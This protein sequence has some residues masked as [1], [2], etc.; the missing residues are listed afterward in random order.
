MTHTKR[1]TSLLLLA[2]LLVGCSQNAIP[3]TQPS[4]SS[5]PAT[6]KPSDSNKSD[7]KSDNTGSNKSDDSPVIDPDD[8]DKEAIIA[9]LSEGFSAENLITS[10]T[11]GMGYDDNYYAFEATDSAYSFRRYQSAD[12]GFATKDYISTQGIYEPFVNGGVKYLTVVE[13]GLD[14][15]LHNYY[16]V[17]ANQNYLRWDTA[18]YINPFARLY[19]DD[20][21]QD[22]NNPY[23]FS[24]I[25][26]D[27]SKTNLYNAFVTA[28]TGISGY[29]LK[30]FTLITDGAT[31]TGYT[32]QVEDV[33]GTYGTTKTSIKGTIDDYK[34]ED[35][36]KTLSPIE[37]SEKQDLE[38]RFTLLRKG[39]YKADITLPNRSYKAEVYGGTAVTY[40]LYKDD[41]K[42]GSYGYYQ[43]GSTVQG[44]TKINGNIYQDSDPISGNMSSMIPTFNISSV[45]FRKDETSTND[46]AIYVMDKEIVDQVSSEGVVYGLLGGTII[47]TLSITLEKDTTTIVN[48]LADSSQEIYV[49]SDVGEIIDFTADIKTSCDD[50]TWSELFS[51]Q[52]ST[53]S[54]LTSKI[55]PEE[56]LDEIPTFGGK[57][58]YINLVKNDRTGKIQTVITIAD[59][60]D[61]QEKIEAYKAKAEALGFAV[62][63]IK[64]QTVN[65][66]F[67][68]EITQNG[69]TK[70][71]TANVLLAASYF[72]TPTIVVTFSSK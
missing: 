23:Q 7:I 18:G 65:Y 30:G 67:S 60:K 4:N 64:S 49:Y 62:T 37:G 1:N 25:M 10:G 53:Y 69:N 27:A 39:N 14:N 42:T 58:S 47:G 6:E 19:G 48:T 31:A 21:V 72:D 28:F 5:K 2:F 45:L 9:E 22:E 11:D 41:V 54:Q 68:K 29:T 71:I 24:L 12:V 40:D 44:I 34:G 51:N 55:I 32:I 35:V 26:G 16:L 52:P 43:I 8:I 17:D 36:V 20:F 50:V 57:S 61:G 66:E 33:K 15:K 63:A 56:F 70:T 59:Y 13:L 3:S 46:K 38:E